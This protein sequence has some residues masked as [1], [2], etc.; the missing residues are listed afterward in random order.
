MNGALRG[1]APVPLFFLLRLVSALLLLKLSAAWLPVSGFAILAQL[2]AWAGF[3][4]LIAIAGTQNGLIREAAAARTAL[5]VAEVQRAGLALWLT[6]GPLIALGIWAG[7]PQLALFLTG[8][9]TTAPA[10]VAMSLL[11]LGA[12]P[13]QVWCSILSG[14]RHVGLG[15][16]TQLAGLIVGTA[17]AGLYIRQG[18]APAAA[19]AFSAGP[20]AAMAL[21]GAAVARL[22]LPGG[23]PPL[24]LSALS[25]LLSYSGALAATAGFTFIALFTLRS[26]Y[27]TAF[28]ATA[29]GYWLMANRISDMSTQLIGLFLIQVF[30]PHFASLDSDRARRRLMV[31][32][33][34]LGVAIM[35]VALLFFLAMSGWLVRLFLSP[36]YIPAIGAIALYMTGDLLRVW[37]SMAMFTL[38]A[39]GRPWSCAAIEMA[40][41]LLM[42]ATTV[43]L[44]AAGRA[45]APMLGY[46]AAQGCAALAVT[47]V[48][49]AGRNRA[50]IAPPPP[51]TA[52]PS[53]RD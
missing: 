51:L 52:A 42:I 22:R 7:S 10:I 21:A 39:R 26:L 27:R 46:V 50:F 29:L 16:G 6:F 28:G 34:A 13:G 3:L 47:I 11:I 20:I 18:N 9:R 33:W 4:N 48:F 25:R 8:D 15:L 41:M 44:V 5:E 2:F 23:L 32:S 43:A 12:G 45:D 19:I 35:A 40:T 31:R 24:S 49:L 38:F 53:P 36:A 1:A 17:G 37:T 14:R 30:V